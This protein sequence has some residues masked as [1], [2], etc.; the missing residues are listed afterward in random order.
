MAGI[1]AG[2]NDPVI[3]MKQPR[4]PIANCE[5]RSGRGALCGGGAAAPITLSGWSKD[6]SVL[7]AVHTVER[8]VEVVLDDFVRAHGRGA[9]GALPI[10]V[11]RT[12]P[13]VQIELQ[14]GGIPHPLRQAFVIDRPPGLVGG[15]ERIVEFLQ[16]AIDS[17]RVAWPQL[18]L[19]I[20]HAEPEVI[21]IIGNVPAIG[22]HG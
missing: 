17:D 8:E 21:G 19:G 3:G 6:V 12:G 1:G 5:G 14:V 18:K 13:A 9:K 22:E 15:A 20:A 2:I 16:P 7:N 4:W 10:L 11:V